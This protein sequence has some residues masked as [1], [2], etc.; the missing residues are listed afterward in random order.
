VARYYQAKA[1]PADAELHED[2]LRFVAL[3]RRL[4]E[5]N[6]HLAD[7]ETPT[8]DEEDSNGAGPAMDAKRRRWHFRA[9]RNPK[10][11]KD[12]KRI[13]GSTCAVCGFNYG[14]RYGDLGE[15]YIEAHHLTPFA[16]LEGRPTKLDPRK[17]FAVVC[18]SCHRMLHRRQP[19]FSLEEIKATL[20]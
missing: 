18:A 12:A 4:V 10:L 11:I 3:Y 1:I 14:D 16:D 15:G 6:D 20:R 2:L 7:A 9:E 19:P 5:A 8:D 13:H 17:D